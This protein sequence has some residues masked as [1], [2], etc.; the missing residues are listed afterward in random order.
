MDLEI[1]ALQCGVPEAAHLCRQRPTAKLK[2]VTK[3]V[4]Q[5]PQVH[6]NYTCRAVRRARCSA[7]ARRA[8]FR[9]ARADGGS[10]SAPCGASSVCSCRGTTVHLRS[11]IAPDV[12][13][14]TLWRELL[15]SSGC[16]WAARGDTSW[17]RGLTRGGFECRL[18]KL[19]VEH[20]GWEATPH[21]AV[22][23][24]GCCAQ[25]RGG[26]RPH[27]LRVGGVPPR[28]IRRLLQSIHEPILV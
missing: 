20:I 23:G 24:G 6:K 5:V 13:P 2:A 25:P 11:D 12:S 1:G 21:Q 15:R 22:L 7:A 28:L 16:T 10:A 9:N 26:G 27:R 4:A 14:I 3:P 17:R 19:T 18:Q 8:A